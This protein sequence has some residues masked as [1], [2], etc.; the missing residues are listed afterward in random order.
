M[1]K[2]WQVPTSGCEATAVIQVVHGRLMNNL[3]CMPGWNGHRTMASAKWRAVTGHSQKWCQHAPNGCAGVQRC[4]RQYAIWMEIWAPSR[5][6]RMCEPQPDQEKRIENHWKT[7]LATAPQ[8]TRQASKVCLDNLPES[9]LL[10]T[11]THPLS[12]CVSNGEGGEERAVAT[13]LPRKQPKNNVGT[14]LLKWK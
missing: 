3:L 8:R 9:A 14:T 5:L 4:S 2:G 7:V 11:R 1:E 12:M 10:I 13:R 6:W